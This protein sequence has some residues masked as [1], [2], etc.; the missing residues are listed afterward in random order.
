MIGS[1]KPL[2]I[3]CGNRCK[4]YLDMVNYDGMRY[5]SQFVG[6]FVK[7]SIVGAFLLKSTQICIGVVQ[8]HA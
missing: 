8:F 4:F 6:N 5:K 2:L 1:G 7:K 3:L